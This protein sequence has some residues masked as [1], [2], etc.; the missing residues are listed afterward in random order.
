ME[1]N[2]TTDTLNYMYR[3]L[4]KYVGTYRVKS[5]YDYGTEDFPRDEL[6]KIDSTFEDLY[7]PCKLGIIKH[8][9]IGNDILVN[10]FY[11]KIKTGIN[12]FER[13]QKKYPKLDIEFE[14]SSPDAFIYFHANDLK[15]IAN[16]IKP[17]TTG[18]SID[19][20]SKKNLPKVHYEIPSKDLTK[21]YKLTQNLDRVET[22][23]FFKKINKDFLESISSSKINYVI[24]AKQSKLNIREFIHS[25][26]LW[27][28]YLEF[29]KK[30]I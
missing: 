4:L 27:D 10:C 2:F 29:V 13:I 30:H 14:E 18:K 3:Y 16:I 5:E 26:N 21:L 7:I 23:H 19:P 17:S 11:N 28:K 20:F 1:V 9:Y 12:T 6:G 24:K 15:Y 25:E 22:L 8:T